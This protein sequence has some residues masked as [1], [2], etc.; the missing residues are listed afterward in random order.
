[1]FYKMKIIWKSWSQLLCKKYRN[2][3]YGILKCNNKQTYSFENIA[4]TLVD[5]YFNS[6]ALDVLYF[7]FKRR[8]PQN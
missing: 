3:A 5:R 6:K 1:M 8:R 2:T 4:N 7:Y